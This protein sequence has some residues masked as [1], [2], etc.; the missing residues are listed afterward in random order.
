MGIVRLCIGGT[1]RNSAELAEAESQT[2]PTSH[3]RVWTV[4]FRPLGNHSRKWKDETLERSFQ[5]AMRVSWECGRDRHV[6]MGTG[7]TS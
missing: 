6:A 2:L 4:F 3:W 5:Q 7:K 1:I